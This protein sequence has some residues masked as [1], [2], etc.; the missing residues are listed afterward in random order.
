MNTQSHRSENP[1]YSDVIG[2]VKEDLWNVELFRNVDTSLN[3]VLDNNIEGS[4]VPSPSLSPES[5]LTVDIKLSSDKIEKTK[6]K[7]LQELEDQDIYFTTIKTNQSENETVSITDPEINEDND[8]IPVS[9]PEKSPLISLNKGLEFFN[10]EVN[11]HPLICQCA[12]CFLPPVDPQRIKDVYQSTTISPTLDLSQTFTLNSLPTANYTIYLDFTGHTTSGTYWNTYFAGGANITTPAFDIDGNPNSFSN[13]ELERIQYIWQR[14]AEDFIPFN[15]NVTTQEPNINDLIKSG[16]GD[17][18]WGVRVAIGGSSYDWYGN[19]A[20]GVAYIDSFNWST[21]TPTFVFTSQLANGDE[22]FTAEAITHEVGHTLGLY[23]D[24]RITPSEEYYYGHGSGETGWASIMGAGYYQNLTQWSKGEYLSANNTED[25]LSIITTQNGFGYRTDDAG[26]TIATA[27]PLIL[28]G[29]SITGSG[30][31]ER[32]TDVDYYSFTTGTGPITLTV[33]P[34]TRGPNLDILAQLYNSSGTL[35]TSSNPADLLSASI[36]TTLASG[37]YYLAIQGTGKGDPLGTGYTN[38][39]SLGQYSIVI[40][41]SITNNNDNFVD[42]I[43]LGS[44]PNTTVTGSNVGA[45]GEVGEPAQSGDI[46]SVWWSWTAPNTGIV[47]ID[48]NGSG[49]DTYLSAFTGST[50]NNL[51]VIQQDDDGGDGT[52]SLVSFVAQQGVEYQIAVDGWSSNTGNITLNLDWQSNVGGIEGSIWDDVNGNGTWDSG[53]NP[54]PNWQVYLDQN[55]NGQFDQGEITT[56]TDANGNYLFEDLA[57]GSY[58]VAEVIPSGWQQTYPDQFNPNSIVSSS[59]VPFVNS[60]PSIDTSPITKPPSPNLNADYQSGELIIKLKDG[61]STA[62]INTLQGSLG[63]KV[64]KSVANLGIQLWSIKN[65]S[66]AEAIALYG[67]SNLVEYIEPN[68]TISINDISTQATPNDPSYSQ[69]WGLHNTGQTGGTVDA[70]I[71]APEAWDITT[72]SSNV[73][74]GVIDTGIDYTHPDLINNMWTNPGEIPNDGIDND[75]NGYIDDVYG[76]DFAYNDSDPMDVPRG[77]NPG[78]GTHVAGTIGG[79]GNNGVGVAGVNWNVQLM[80]LKFLDD[81]G[82]GSTFNAILAINYA[83]M[84]GVNLTNNSWGGGGYSQG[85]YDAISAAGNAGQLFVASAGNDGNNNDAFASYP[86]TYN[87]DNIIS[88]AATDHNDQLASFSNYGA[89]TVD[90]AAPGVNIYSTFPNNTYGSISGTSMASPHVAGVA[91]LLLAN[92]PDLTDEEV[93][94]AILSGVDLKANLAGTN[95]TGGRL[96]AYNALIYSTPVPGTHAVQVTAGQTVQGI[97]F[98]NQQIP[99]VDINI[100]GNQTVVEGM[101]NP[102]NV[103]ITVILSQ[104]S[105]QTVTV[106]YATANGSAIAGSDYTNT[107]GTLTFTPGET[108]KVI[109]V[110]IL[111]D[112]INEPDETFTVTLS[113]PTN[114]VIVSATSTVTIT[115]TLSSNT[116]TTLPAGVENLTLTGTGNINGTGN[117]GNNRMTGNSGNNRL[118]G[119]DGNDTLIGGAGNDTLSGGTG[120]DSMVGG[121][122][123][124]LYGVDNPSDVIIELANQGIDTVNSSI[125]YTLGAN[126]EN[127]TLT[128]TANISGTGNTLN[129]VIRGNSGNNRLNGGDGNDT[130]IGGAGNDTLSGGTG[131]DSMVGGPGDDLYGVDNPSDVIIELANQG[132]DTVNSSITYTL[133]ANLENLTLTGTANISGTG[134]TFKQCHQG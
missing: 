108:S 69:L 88:V 105:S 99:L 54:L 46:N 10:S 55:R 19:G 26:N 9:P 11:F 37:T 117:A 12:S 23:H 67:D 2:L 41:P 111:N 91:A 70:D 25:D 27:T 49:F 16:S 13:A 112:N 20:G 30:I 87:L 103:T 7:N 74:V 122:G 120:A 106:Q 47:T 15:V 43:D 98:G 72:G 123:D 93:K 22:K 39:G 77:D 3:L 84:M 79:R 33:N 81:Y 51:T 6:F 124:D 53:E 132:I 42:R 82:N 96:N 28:S 109:N 56:V 129:N 5:D 104:A 21:D 110:P 107:T 63:A 31:I 76:Y 4:I 18:R 128:G 114:G 80:A 14:V 115:D 100:G 92:N 65:M 75:G 130:L 35:I 29:T 118:N 90:L 1:L 24:G 95:L 32:N 101:T 131:A 71:D 40:N 38:Y 121:P 94:A 8:D 17:T 58:V 85:L 134:N 133:G 57:P 78:H 127:L 48:T 50:V 83:T 64:V 86:A 125:T 73:I 113:N 59:S 102:Q 119:G 62:E 97:N 52:N 89:T 116:T 68:Y 36:N 126:L 60:N 45:T 61:I 66:V 34:F 44:V